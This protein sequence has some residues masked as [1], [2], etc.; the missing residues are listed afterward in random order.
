MICIGKRS[1]GC[2]SAS[3][4]TT[5]KGTPA[6]RSAAAIRKSIGAG[7]A[8][9]ATSSRCACSHA[10]QAGRANGIASSRQAKPGR[11]LVGADR[12]FAGR[13]PRRRHDSR[14]LDRLSSASMPGSAVDRLGKLGRE[15]RPG[16][17]PPPLPDQHPHA[18]TSPNA[19]TAARRPASPSRCSATPGRRAGE[20][21]RAPPGHRPGAPEG[22]GRIDVGIGPDGALAPR[23]R[24]A[25]RGRGS[26]A[27]GP[28]PRSS[29]P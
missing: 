27:P 3:C 11:A 17:A 13:R 2:E 9:I 7:M 4:T 1:P 10:R 23:T 28:S 22:G 24:R 18:G 16:A 14:R 8:Q 19:V 21:R 12:Q 5:A 25:G 29:H 26:A 15:T 6:R 20:R